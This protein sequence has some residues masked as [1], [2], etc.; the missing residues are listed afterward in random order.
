MGRLFEMDSPIMRFLSRVA[1]LLML[2][3]L[4][5]VCC[6]PVITIGA[7]FT[8]MHYVLLKM[9][10]GE[11]GYLFRGFFKSFKQNFKQATL[12]WI[13]MLA[14]IVIYVCDLVIINY[15]GVEFPKAVVIAVAAVGFVV[16]L[17]GMYVFPVLARFDNTIKNTIRNAAILMFANLPKTLLTVVVYA[18]PLVIG[19]FSTYSLIFIF[20][21]G[22]TVPAYAAACLYSDIFKRFEPENELTSDLD[23]SIDAGWEEE[24]GEKT[25]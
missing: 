21:F 6:M 20:M 9:V 23:F 1:D 3:L 8:A 11:E 15:S 24:P 25:E 19:Y 12:I 2:N 22:I 7:A 17:I 18:L 14:V 16:F 5:I 10:R 4:M 13:V